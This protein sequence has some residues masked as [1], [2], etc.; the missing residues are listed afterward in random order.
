MDGVRVWQFVKLANLSGLEFFM[1][2]RKCWIVQIFCLGFTIFFKVPTMSCCVVVFSSV[3]KALHF[4]EAAAFAFSLRFGILLLPIV[5]HL[6]GDL[7][8]N[9]LLPILALNYLF[10]YGVNDRY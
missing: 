2:R 8:R 4:D 7:S 5:T 6:I 3:N 10:L 9:L 1:S